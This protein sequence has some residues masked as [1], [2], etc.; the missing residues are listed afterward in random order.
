M[1]LLTDGSQFLTHW[2]KVACAQ[3]FM[4]TLLYI[5]L[6]V[7]IV[8]LKQIVDNGRCLHYRDFMYFFTNLEL[9]A[10]KVCHGCQ[11]RTLTQGFTGLF[12]ECINEGTVTLVGY[13]SQRIDVVYS[14]AQAF[15]IHANALLVNADTQ[16]TAYLLAFCCRAAGMAQRTYLEH[17]GVVPSFTQS[18]VREDETC[19]LIEAQQPF[20]VFQNQVV[21]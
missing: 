2:C 15:R 14:F 19:R 9:S 10:F 6:V 12:L 8:I 16:S 5:A 21:C 4:I 17:I 20:L 7:H 1:N 13:N 11:R 3:V 18:R